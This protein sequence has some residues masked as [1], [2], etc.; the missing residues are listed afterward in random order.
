MEKCS[1]CGSE[2]IDTEPHYIPLGTDNVLRI[3]DQ[4]CPQ[5]GGAVIGKDQKLKLIKNRELHDK[6][7]E[8]ICGR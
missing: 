3:I 6:L 8:A 7:I 4:T 2:L 1:T 5:C